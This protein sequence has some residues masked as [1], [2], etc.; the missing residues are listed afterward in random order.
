MVVQNKVVAWKFLKSALKNIRDDVL[1]KSLF[2]E[3]R[4]RAF[5]EWGF[6]PETTKINKENKI[7][8]DDWEKEF[9]EDIEKTKAYELDIRKEKREKTAAEAKNRMR[10]FIEGGG[11]YSDLPDYLQNK[12]IAR[13]YLDTLF[14]EIQNCED[15]LEKSPLQ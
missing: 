7:E 12:H 8:L 10:Q 11:K 2:A 5:E 4:K 14:E 9:V 3:F 13:L 6:D 15:F 1:R